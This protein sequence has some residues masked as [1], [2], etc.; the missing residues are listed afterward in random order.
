VYC[1]HLLG[2]VETNTLTQN[3]DWGKGEKHPQN[4]YVLP[5]NLWYYSIRQIK[6]SFPS[7]FVAANKN[8]GDFSDGLAFERR[9][10]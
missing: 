4:I 2:G 3:G 6:T 8:T 5:K 10:L 7:I 9:D 1:R